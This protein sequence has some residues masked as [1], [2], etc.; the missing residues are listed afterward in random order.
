M[1]EDKYSVYDGD[2]LI[3]AK[4]SLAD[5]LLFIKAVFEDAYN[6]TTLNLTIKR[7]ETTDD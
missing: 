1:L 4:M 3:A 7:E 5:A 6:D 2:S